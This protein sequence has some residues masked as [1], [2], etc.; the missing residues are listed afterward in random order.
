MCKREALKFDV[1]S[2]AAAAAAGAS[3]EATAD[4]SSVSVWTWES[5][6]A[7]FEKLRPFATKDTESEVDYRMEAW[8][9]AYATSYEREK[10]AHADMVREQEKK[11]RQ[12]LELLRKRTSKRTSKRTR[13]PEPPPAVETGV[14]STSTEPPP[15]Q[16]PP[17]PAS[18]PQRPRQASISQRAETP[19]PPPIDEDPPQPVP[20]QTSFVE[21]PP[22]YVAQAQVTQAAPPR[23]PARF[24][25]P[26]PPPREPLPRPH[27]PRGKLRRSKDGKREGSKWTELLL[28]GYFHH[29][30]PG[31]VDHLVPLGD[32]MP[33]ATLRPQPPSHATWLCSRVDVIDAHNDLRDKTLHVWP[34]DVKPLQMALT[35]HCEDADRLA[36]ALPWPPLLPTQPPSSRPPSSSPLSTRHPSSKLPTQLLAHPPTQISSSGKPAASGARTA[37][38]SGGVA[39]WAGD[40]YAAPGPCAAAGSA[41][42]EAWRAAAA[43]EAV[44]DVSHRLA[45]GLL[46]CHAASPR[47]MGDLRL[48]SAVMGARR[49][50]TPATL[51]YAL[52]VP[53]SVRPHSS[54]REWL[55]PRGHAATRAATE[56]LSV[57]TDRG[58]PARPQSE[59]GG[60][61]R[62]FT[63]TV[64][65]SITGIPT[66]GVPTERA[67]TVRAQTARAALGTA[68]AWTLTERGAQGPRTGTG[69]ALLPPSD[70]GMSIGAPTRPTSLRAHTRQSANPWPEEASGWA[71]ETGGGVK[72]SRCEDVEARIAF[73]SL[74]A[75]AAPLGPRDAM[76]SSGEGVGNPYAPRAVVSAPRGLLGMDEGTFNP[77]DTSAAALMGPYALQAATKG[78]L[79]ARCEMRSKTA[80]EPLHELQLHPQQ[81]PNGWHFVSTP[82][83]RG[84]PVRRIYS[85]PT[86]ALTSAGR[87]TLAIQDSSD[88]S[89]GVQLASPR[90]FPPWYSQQ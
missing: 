66:V 24:N 60:S 68:P 77:Y 55:S 62:P 19:P 14:V 49:P 18:P 58:D 81:L 36:N 51:P 3:E 11:L 6:E 83:S 84:D 85:R 34:S 42:L 4:E 70:R 22:P 44:A 15:R 48:R 74:K 71:S 25:R 78:F 80:A 43:P 38:W 46:T 54:H 17:R 1:V 56:P 90:A 27:P 10:K 61:R 39:G 87:G 31:G 75:A 37:V 89:A 20:P 57:D 13:A 72:M 79:S 86:S 26:P 64:R 88:P 40:W 33:S 59:P 8:L 35:S 23:R 32:V 53:A 21:A 82:G 9:K 29:D 5:D 67:P 52:H 50:P 7:L 41:N 65:D 63:A 47:A 76:P 30:S 12:Q 45:T 2:V 28:R 69:T 16:P 73:D